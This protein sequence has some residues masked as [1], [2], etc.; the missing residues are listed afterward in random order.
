MI[1]QKLFKTIR[2]AL[3][4]PD[5]VLIHGRLEP[6][7]IPGWDSLAWINIINAVE[8]CFNKKL[9]LE[10]LA[11]VQTV[12]DFIVIIQEQLME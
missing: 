2:T 10:R 4:L 5:D 6:G 3:E 11:E 7:E 8:D 1:E 9:P 12:G